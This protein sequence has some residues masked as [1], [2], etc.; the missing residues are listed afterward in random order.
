MEWSQVTTNRIRQIARFLRN[1]I[2]QALLVV[3]ASAA[4]LAAYP[5]VLH[6]W[7]MNW[8]ST[9]AERV[10]PLPG[11]EYPLDGRTYFNRAITIEAPASAVW[12][13]LVQIGQDRAGFYSNDYL[14]NLTGA[15]IHNA[16]EIHP[17]WQRRKAGDTIPMARP[18][19][20][21]GAMGDSLLL[22]VTAVQPGRMMTTEDGSNMPERYFI[23]P[24]D[25]GTTR[26]LLRERYMEPVFG[27]IGATWI[28]DPMHFVMEQRMLQGIKE[29]AEGVPLVPA[30]LALG[31][32]AGWILAGLAVAGLFL[33]RRR[34]IPVGLLCAALMIPAYLSAGD[35]N[36]AVAGFLALGISFAGLMLFGWRWVIAYPLV[37]ASVLLVLLLT[38]DSWTAFGLI[39]DAVAAGVAAKTL[40]PRARP[41]AA[42]AIRLEFAQ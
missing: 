12:Q 20:L 14:E 24:V 16:N 6:P 28:F 41:G 31:S 1:P 29:R 5:T 10:M 23:L 22:R 3:L 8:G 40:V 38:P 26:L 32:G 9:Q 39:F 4:L 21:G 19:L 13:W 25:K 30:W 36:S 15:D 2:L 42:R 37:A 18:D 7:M 11:D 33:S 17:E 35:F 27:E 34:W